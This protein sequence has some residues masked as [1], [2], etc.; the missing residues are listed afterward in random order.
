MPEV[1]KLSRYP[2]GQ[3]FC[4]RL[5]DDMPA[6]AT[7]TML[8]PKGVLADHIGQYTGFVARN[9]RQRQRCRCGSNQTE[10]P[11]QCSLQRYYGAKSALSSVTAFGWLLLPDAS[12]GARR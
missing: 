8:A 6:T 5:R 9:Q 3:G 1:S 4:L 12:L 10:N 7:I 2:L 11:I